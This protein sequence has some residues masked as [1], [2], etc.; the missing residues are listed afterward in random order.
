MA[1]EQSR[2]SPLIALCERI[3]WRHL[4][5]VPYKRYKQLVYEPGVS[6]LATHT[7]ILWPC[8]TRTDE[9]ALGCGME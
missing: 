8:E 4:L 6:R 3:V 9:H 1:V 5:T 7:P 2:P